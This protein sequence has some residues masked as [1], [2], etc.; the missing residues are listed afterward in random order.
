[1]GWFIVTR[2]IL[3]RT[4]FAL[5]G[6]TSIWLLAFVTGDA[7]SWYMATSLMGLM[8]ETAFTLFRKRGQEWKWYVNAAIF[9]TRSLMFSAAVLV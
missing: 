4:L 8:F 6:V 1:M 2:A 3:V 7:T 9:Y 5:H